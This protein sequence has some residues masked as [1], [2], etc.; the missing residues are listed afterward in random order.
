MNIPLL[1]P[2]VLSLPARVI[3]A[4]I[5]ATIL[6]Q[7]GNRLLQSQQLNHRLKEIEAKHICLHVRD[8]DQ[9]LFFRINNSRLAPST[10]KDWDIKISGNFSDFFALATRTEDPDTLF[11]NRSLVLEGK[12]ETGLYIKNL[13]DAV[14]LG[15]EYQIQ[16]LTGKKP[17]EFVSQAITKTADRL[18]SALGF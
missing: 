17:P 7:L 16:A 18:R 15:I 10:N 1:I 3:P 11:F 12:T 13:L 4:V 14:D 2:K 6:A 9:S 8:I 5:P